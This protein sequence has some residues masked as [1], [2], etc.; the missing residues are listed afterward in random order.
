MYVLNIPTKLRNTVVNVYLQTSLS[1]L[2][3]SD[4]SSYFVLS[5]IFYG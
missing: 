4:K 2:K 1:A 3:G 5:V